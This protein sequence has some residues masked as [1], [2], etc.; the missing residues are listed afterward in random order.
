MEGLNVMDVERERIPLLW[1]TVEETALAKRF[2]FNILPFYT[3][4]SVHDQFLR[5]ARCI[6]IYVLMSVCCLLFT[7]FSQK[8][9]GKW[10]ESRCNQRR[11]FNCFAP[12]EI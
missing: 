2:C 5:S 9:A 1:S 6:Q 3:S 4:F 7:C 10:S 8:A 12:G 11:W